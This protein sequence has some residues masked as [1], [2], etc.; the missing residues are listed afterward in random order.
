[1]RTGDSYVLGGERKKK[2]EREKEKGEK[3]GGRGEREGNRSSDPLSKDYKASGAA[4]R[5]EYEVC[6]SETNPPYFANNDPNV[7]RRKTF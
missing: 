1:M 3:K 4:S 2:R 7:V 6:Y 5:S